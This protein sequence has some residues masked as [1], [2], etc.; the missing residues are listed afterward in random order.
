MLPQSSHSTIA[1]RVCC[2]FVTARPQVSSGTNFAEGWLFVQILE[3]I[4]GQIPSNRELCSKPG[5]KF[6]A[7][8]PGSCQA[9]W[10]LVVGL[11]MLLQLPVIDGKEQSPTA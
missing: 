9:P 2:K 10:W 11:A 4:A 1:G 5:S 7:V 6:L 8:E 3:P